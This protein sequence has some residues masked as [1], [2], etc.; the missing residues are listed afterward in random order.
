[1]RGWRH[2]MPLP[3]FVFGEAAT[4]E[5]RRECACCEHQY[6]LPI[7]A[8]GQNQPWGSTS[9][10]LRVCT[11]TSFHGRVP[12]ECG[13]DGGG[14]QMTEKRLRITKTRGCWWGG[15]ITPAHT[16]LSARPVASTVCAVSSALAFSRWLPHIVQKSETQSSKCGLPISE[17][18]C[19]IA[20]QKRC[21]F[22]NPVRPIRDNG[23]AMPTAEF[24]VTVHDIFTTR[25]WGR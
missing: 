21:R 23:V 1:M 3:S 14:G 7:S 5:L 25:S 6:T 13:K 18:C 10:T 16:L 17:P 12:S 2:C 15:G 24:V 20:F 11:V 4:S 22:Y 19:F 9:V 8:C